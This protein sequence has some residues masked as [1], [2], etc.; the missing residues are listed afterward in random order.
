MDAAH[1]LKAAREALGLTQHDV[2]ARSG[3]QRPNIA[4]YETGKRIPSPEMLTRILASLSP[5]PSVRLLEH[6]AEVVALAQRHR[7]V[8]VRV[9][10][11]IARGED[12]PQSDVDLLV[13]WAP[14]ASL[15][16]HVSLVEDL[17]A[18]LGAEVD[19]VSDRVLKG[20]KGPGIRRD[21]K[22]LV[23]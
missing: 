14:G 4:A 23:G 22:A 5:R 6:E 2:A 11:S 1:T 13:T 7:A 15:F 20:R 12:G 19:I 21:A 16:D 9:F 17:Q 3:V 18:L 8:N 10:G